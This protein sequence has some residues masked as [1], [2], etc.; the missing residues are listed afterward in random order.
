MFVF[1][2]ILYTFYSYV[3]IH[4][5]GS[6]RDTRNLLQGFSIEL[7]TAGYLKTLTIPGSTDLYRKT[8]AHYRTVGTYNFTAYIF[9]YF[10]YEIPLFGAWK[11][12]L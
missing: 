3:S 10:Y 5:T 2:E 6:P 4:C 8:A 1:N 11:I 7:M 12:N 9:I